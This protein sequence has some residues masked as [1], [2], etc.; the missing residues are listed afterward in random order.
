[1]EFSRMLLPLLSASLEQY[2]KALQT[3][4]GDWRKFAKNQLLPSY[5]V[6]ALLLRSPE[7]IG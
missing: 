5:S 6:P 1:M 7:K 4:V 2:I 3:V